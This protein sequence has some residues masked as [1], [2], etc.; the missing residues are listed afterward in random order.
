MPPLSKMLV[1]P[2]NLLPASSDAVHQAPIPP[3]SP[4][5]ANS[6]FTRCP[7]PP[8]N[9]ASPDGV[10]LFAQSRNTVPLRSRLLPPVV[11]NTPTNLTINETVAGRATSSSLVIEVSGSTTLAGDTDV[12]IIS[13]QNDQALV[14]NT[15]ISKWRNQTLESLP[16]NPQIGDIPR[17]NVNG[18][19]NW[20][21]VN[22]IQAFIALYAQ[23]QSS[24]LAAIGQ[25]SNVVGTSSSVTGSQ[26]TINATATLGAGDHVSAAAS[27][28]TSTVIGTAYGSN[29]SV[30]LTGI[31]AFY[32]WSCRF[33][34]GSTVNARY[35]IGLACLNSGGTGNNGAA[36]VG[37]TAYAQDTPNKTTIG[38]RYSDGTDSTWQ[39]VVISAS[40]SA[41][42]Q[43]T[44]D[45]GVAPD[46]HIHLFEMATN[47]TGTEILFLID[48]VV[49][50]TISTNI[51]NPSAGGNSLGSL[52]F[53]GDNK[54]TNTAISLVFYSMQ[55]S[56][57][58]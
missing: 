8:V 9:P 19:G 49:V 28:S 54:N 40:S 57:K 4:V 50:A 45:T 33:S 43:T 30:S 58:Y 31:T 18:D 41:G 26:S 39:A 52:F 29:G 38:F 44:V 2:D 15:T 46:T 17:F 3:E 32:R 16:A 36:I 55:M 47:I 7:L 53:T 35:W 56:L 20:D 37:T 12:S 13:P 42:L 34:L 51:P 27:A 6:M 14:Y 25:L 48:G 10:Q 24:N 1:E 21:A 5:L 23:N 22:S 11:V